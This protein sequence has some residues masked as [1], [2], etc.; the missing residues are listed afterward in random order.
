M[1]VSNIFLSHGHDSTHDPALPKMRRFYDA[2]WSEA[3]AELLDQLETEH[4]DDP[5]LS[6]KVS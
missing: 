3:M 5:S 2:V 1:L 4:P 6:P